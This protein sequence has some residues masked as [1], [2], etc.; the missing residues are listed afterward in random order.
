MS[1]IILTETTTHRGASNTKLCTMI[2]GK[3]FCEVKETTS[4]QAGSIILGIF[5]AIV[6]WTIL[7]F[8]TYKSI[9]TILKL[10]ELDEWS[11][12]VAI[13]SF[14]APLGYLGLFLVIFN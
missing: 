3:K 8:I 14:V 7:S 13:F 1:N 4:A 10:E 5:G 6:F 11:L 12:A 2:E 9:M